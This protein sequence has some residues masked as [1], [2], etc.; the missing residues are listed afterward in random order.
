METHSLVTARFMIQPLIPDTWTAVQTSG[1]PSARSGHVVVWTGT[2]MLI[3]GGE[4]ASGALSSGGAYDVSANKWRSL[5]TAGSPVARA[6]SR[7]V[8]SGTELLVFGGEEG[9]QP[10]ASLQR[11]NPQPAWHFYRKL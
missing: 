2:E 10:I 11:L 3:Y 4:D 7:A 1:A 6:N 5:N 8:W 9:G